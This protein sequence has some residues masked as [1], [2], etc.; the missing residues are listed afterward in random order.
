MV[1]LVR[2]GRYTL[3]ETRSQIKILTL[4]KSI[5]Y[6]WIY[7]KDIGEL[8]VTSHV[9]HRTDQI[10]SVGAYRLYKVKDEPRLTDLLHLELIVG[11]GLWQG[12]LLPTGLP[13]GEKK[14]SRII[15]TRE[16]IT[17]SVA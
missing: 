7:A 12:Y 17:K 9:K 8:L 5:V 10:L 6:A 16:T 15:P 3:I 1:T 2:T 13:K 14:R 11:D 4:D